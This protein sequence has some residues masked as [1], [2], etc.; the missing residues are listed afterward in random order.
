MESSIVYSYISGIAYSSI[1][2]P[3][4]GRWLWMI[5][6]SCN[7]KYNDFFR[8]ALYLDQN[9]LS[10]DCNSV[11]SHFYPSPG[12]FCIFSH[13]IYACRNG[14]SSFQECF[15]FWNW[16]L[17]QKF[18]PFSVDCFWLDLWTCPASL[19][20][21][22]PLLSFLGCQKKCKAD[23]KYEEDYIKLL[24][25]WDFWGVLS[26]EFLTQPIGQQTF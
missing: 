3:D 22:I 14:S 23:S 16:L 26:I 12:P 25:M 11:S 15:T 5:A 8:K 19:C 10:L 17:M 21:A 2:E 7:S 6:L 20:R 4:L 9:V 18:K 1:F 24:K 13:I